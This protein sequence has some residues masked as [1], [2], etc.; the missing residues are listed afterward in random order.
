MQDTGIFLFGKT[1]ENTKP[2]GPI[3]TILCEWE[4]FVISSGAYPD[5]DDLCPTSL[6]GR[7]Y[8]LL[9]TTVSEVRAITNTKQNNTV[10]KADLTNAVYREIGLSQSESSKLVDSVFEK[11]ELSL[12]SDGIV[13]LP[14]FGKFVTR[15]KSARPGRN[16]KTGEPVVISPRRVVIFK[17]SSKLTKR[18]N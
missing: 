13:K 9:G 10:K 11:I 1:S 12:I 18:V 17:P 16:P 15:L 7:T 5:L 3:N 6:G 2:P 4:V 14:G 8:Y